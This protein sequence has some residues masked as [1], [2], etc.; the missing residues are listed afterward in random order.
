MQEGEKKTKL[1][2]REDMP[3][4]KY[5]NF[6]RELTLQILDNQKTDQN[7]RSSRSEDA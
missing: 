4:Q 5:A 6:L 2:F 3:F 1:A 7:I